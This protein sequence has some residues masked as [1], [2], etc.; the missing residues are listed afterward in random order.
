MAQIMDDAEM[1]MEEDEIQAD[2]MFAGED[3]NE[4]QFS[5]T[6]DFP[7]IVL[8]NS[9]TCK[10]DPISDDEMFLLYKTL[11]IPID[12]TGKI[13]NCYHLRL[14][15]IIFSLFVLDKKFSHWRLNSV[16]IRGVQNMSTS[17]V[18]DY[19]NE[20]EPDHIEWVNDYSC[21]LSPSFH[22]NC[23]K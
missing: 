6:I 1:N 10:P 15:I 21:K 2:E 9:S 4:E 17:D 7:K 19:F 12:Q 5:S 14:L 16:H 18:L 22:D 20:F 11:G 13:Y 8:C 3:V 23:G